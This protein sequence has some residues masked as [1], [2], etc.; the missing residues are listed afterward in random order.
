MKG[1]EKTDV[2]KLPAKVRALYDVLSESYP[3]PVAIN[4]IQRV[5]GYRYSARLYELRK[6]LLYP[7]G[8][9]VMVFHPKGYGG[10]FRA[11]KMVRIV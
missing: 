7:A 10:N 9:D 6:R 5:A 3:L 4:V 2:E 11:Y 8:W 1:I